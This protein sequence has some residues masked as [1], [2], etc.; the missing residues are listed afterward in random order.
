MRIKRVLRALAATTTVLTLMFVCGSV[1]RASE[2]VGTI[3]STYKYG[4]SNVGGYVNFAPTQAGLTITDTGITGYAWSANSGFINFDT[5]LSGVTNDGEG[6]LGGFAWAEGAGWISFTGVTIDSTGRF[7]GTA[8]GGT[9]NG[10]SYTITFDCTNCDVRTDWRPAST[11][12]STDSSSG[13]GSSGGSSR[14]TRPIPDELPEEP[15][16]PPPIEPGQ[17]SSIPSISEGTV[18]GPTSTQ[19]WYPGQDPE[20]TQ[21]IGTATPAEQLET[22]TPTS[23]KLFFFILGFVVLLLLLFL[24]VARTRRS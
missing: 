17:Q 2:S 3:D 8:V 12:T 23:Y 11:R 4:W 16:I 6:T 19:T 7:A 13:Q 10:A 22:S 21:D 24:A 1:V 15:T 14:T 9:V 20:V 18:P 5:A